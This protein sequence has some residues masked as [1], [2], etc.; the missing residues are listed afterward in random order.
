MR[1]PIVIGT[2]FRAEAD[3]ALDRAIL[4]GEA[5]NS[6]VVVVHALDPDDRDQP[7][8]AELERRLQGVL[9]RTGA[10]V[11]FRCHEGEANA[12][13]TDVAHEVGAAIIVLGVARYNSFRDYVLGTTVDYAIRDTSL[14][15][16]VVKSRPRE[17]YRRIVS[18]TDFHKPSRIALETAAD[19]FPDCPLEVVHAFHVPFEGWQRAEYVRDQVAEAEQKVFDEFMA[20]LRPETRARITQHLAYGNVHTAM[21]RELE[22]G[23]ADLVVIGTHGDSALRHATL[24][25]TASELLRLTPID[26]LVVGPKV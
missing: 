10:H 5:W 15:V 3:R 13:I 24:G 17:Q 16:L 25:S 19:L 23:G 8:Q 4:L 7:T 18:A 6:E 21:L 9:P 14:P 1:G 26:T 11:T 22:E 2:D 20:E 12:V